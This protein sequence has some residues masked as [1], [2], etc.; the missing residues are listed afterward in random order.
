MR[1]RRN[2]R[3]DGPASEPSAVLRQLLAGTGK[4]PIDK[5]EAKRYAAEIE[6]MLRPPPMQPVGVPAGATDEALHPQT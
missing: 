4:S 2:A 5:P 3:A 6:A 1:E